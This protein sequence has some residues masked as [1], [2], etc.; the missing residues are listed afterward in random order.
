MLT[1]LW[2]AGRPKA[3][4][5]SAPGTFFRPCPKILQL[6]APEILAKTDVLCSLDCI[7]EGGHLT[8]TCLLQ[9]TKKK[10]TKDV[11][12]FACQI[13]YK[14]SLLQWSAR[15]FFKNLSL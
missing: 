14:A 8:E 11:F 5:E 6:S 9:K 13:P 7:T 2:E 1:A 10:K 12:I 4:P 15:V 3:A